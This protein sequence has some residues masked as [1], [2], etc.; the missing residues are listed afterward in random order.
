LGKIKIENGILQVAEFLNRN[1]RN[2]NKKTDKIRPNKIKNK[3]KNYSWL[4]W[5]IPF[6]FIVSYYSGIKSGLMI[7][8]L[9]ICGVLLGAIIPV[10][11]GSIFKK[12]NLK[13]IYGEIAI[14]IISTL[15]LYS[16]IPNKKL[17]LFMFPFAVPTLIV[18]I[19]DLRRF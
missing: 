8:G 10:I 17:L 19:L 14:F 3:L 1:L 5:T 15:L 18:G 9:L 6:F 13:I 2:M 4:V 11:I 7:S 12:Y 16:F